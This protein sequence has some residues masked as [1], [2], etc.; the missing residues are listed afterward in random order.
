M[1]FFPLIKKDYFQHRGAP[2][3]GVFFVMEIVHELLKLLEEFL[4]KSLLMLAV[5]LATLGFQWYNEYNEH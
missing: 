1:L 3:N 4:A 2:F 5:L